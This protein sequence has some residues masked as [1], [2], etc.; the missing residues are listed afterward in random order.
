MLK[1]IIFGFV[2]LVFLLLISLLIMIRV[3]LTLYSFYAQSTIESTI[4]NQAAGQ[5][6]LEDTENIHDH[7]GYVS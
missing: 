5:A 2:G 1:K 7:S 6:L 4:G 3:T